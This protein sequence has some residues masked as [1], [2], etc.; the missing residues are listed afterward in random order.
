MLGRRRGLKTVAGEELVGVSEISE[1]EGEIEVFWFRIS[2]KEWT[3]RGNEN[4]EL[5]RIDEKV[6]FVWGE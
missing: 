1:T 2:S 6:E 4:W 5:N 3:I